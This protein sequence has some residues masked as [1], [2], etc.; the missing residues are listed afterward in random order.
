MSIILSL[1]Y[2]NV[3]AWSQ[4][5]WTIEVALYQV[6]HVSISIV[7]AYVCSHGGN[8]GGRNTPRNDVLLK[9]GVLEV[10]QIGHSASDPTLVLDASVP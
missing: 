6:R 8:P 1:D 9:S 3:C 2:P 5:V 7:T 4:L 10:T